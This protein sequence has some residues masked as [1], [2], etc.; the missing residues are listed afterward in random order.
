MSHGHTVILVVVDRY[1]K[2]A[3]FGALPTR[4][5]AHQVA[6][7]FVDMVCKHHGFPRSF[8]SNRDAL[9][10]S[11]FWKELFRLSGTQLRMS[12]A[13]HPQSDGQ[14]E[15]VNRTLEQYLRAYTHHKPSQWYR[16]LHLAEWCYNTTVH[17]GTGF[18][19]SE[20]I[21]GRPPPTL[22]DYIQGSSPINAVDSMLTD[23]TELHALLQ[24]RLLKAQTSMKS[25][26]DKHRRDTHFAVGDW[27][28]LRLHPYRQTSLLPTYSKLAKRFYGPY[29]VL[30]RIGPVAYRLALPNDSRIQYVFHVSLLKPHNGPLPPIDT[31]LPPLAVDHHPVVTPLTILD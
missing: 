24:R 30:E 25:A 19:P 4:H 7:R 15:V 18:A 29:Q 17:S 12:T 5:T 9:F 14:T 31:P 21:Y 11:H 8:V 10:L 26:A 16:Y 23:R 1:S 28:Y 13:Y 20:V 2:G 6:V 27:V 22:V 3:H